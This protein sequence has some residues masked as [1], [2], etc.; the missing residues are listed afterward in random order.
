MKEKDREFVKISLGMDDSQTDE[1]FEK[2]KA[3]PESGDD[4]SRENYVKKLCDN[5]RGRDRYELT[6]IL[7]TRLV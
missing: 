6:K 3:M 2:L 7:M 1:L 5:M 4:N